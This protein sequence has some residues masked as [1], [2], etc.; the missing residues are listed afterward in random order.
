LLFSYFLKKKK[1]PYRYFDKEVKYRIN[2]K[3]RKSE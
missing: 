3:T 2:D 1:T